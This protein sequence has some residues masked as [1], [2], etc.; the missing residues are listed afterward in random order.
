MKL[1]RR[2][3]RNLIESSIN[4]DIVDDTLSK[5]YEAQIGD[6]VPGGMSKD[7]A[8]MSLRSALEEIAKIHSV[9]DEQILQEFEIGVSEEME[10]TDS[11]LIATEIALDHLVEAPDYYTRL[12]AA[13][14]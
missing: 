5:G 8:T 4:E 14:L 12:E 7:L 6:L 1:S 9:E 3:L 10:H 13:G 11:I 2:N